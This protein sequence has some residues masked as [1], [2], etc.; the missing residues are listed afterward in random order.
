LGLMAALVMLENRPP[1]RQTVA[2]TA[3]SFDSPYDRV[4]AALGFEHAPLVGW[5]LRFYGRNSRFKAMLLLS[6]PLLAFLTFNIGGRK[7]GVGLFA[8][9]LGTFPIVTFLATAR[10]MVNQFGYLGGGYRRCFLLPVAP[11]TV[12]RTGSYASMLL[13]VCL[14]PVA[15]I[16]WLALAP[17][18]FDA[19]QIVM[20]LCSAFTGLFL[21]H[22]LG[23][24]ATLYGPR[25]G[26]YNQSLG[27]DLS[28][29]GNV[30]VIGGV[31]TCLF[32]ASTLPKLLPG[33]VD[34]ANW[35]MWLAAPIA[36]VV[37]YSASLRAAS[38]L[39]RGKREE[40]MAIVE[41]KA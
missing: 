5:W 16:A 20:L 12:L 24:W 31:L 28:L 33:A 10:F 34:P 35:W 4:A 23:L 7:N 25:K 21:F 39:L 19:R 41:G 14:I 9:A 1:Q 32:G 27:N 18:P 2:T 29:M 6:V 36:G 26:N 38:G 40:L 3:M 11:A 30:I 17:L 37:F 13:S 15:V 8:A 22:A